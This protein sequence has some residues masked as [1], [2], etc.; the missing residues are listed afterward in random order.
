MEIGAQTIMGDIVAMLHQWK[1]LANKGP[2]LALRRW[3]SQVA[4]H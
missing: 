2:M 1:D 4:S 3:F